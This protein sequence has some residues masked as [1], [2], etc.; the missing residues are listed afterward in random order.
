[1]YKYVNISDY[2][3]LLIRYSLILQYLIEAFDNQ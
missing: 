1:M 2:Y 3:R